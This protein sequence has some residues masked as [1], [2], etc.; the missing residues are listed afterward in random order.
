MRFRYFTSSVISSILPVKRVSAPMPMPERDRRLIVD[1]DIRGLI[2]REDIR[3]R[4]LDAPFRDSLA[5][6]EQR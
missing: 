6:H 2:R 4:L 3:L 5:I 1:A